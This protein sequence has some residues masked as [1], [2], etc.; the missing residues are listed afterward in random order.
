MET[1][2]KN[3]WNIIKCNKKKIIG[4]ASNATNKFVFMIEY[5]KKLENIGIMNLCYYKICC[6]SKKYPPQKNENKF[7]YGKLVEKSL[8]EAFCK[9][10]FICEDLDKKHKFGSEYKNDIT[11]LGM[12]VSM[13]S[14][15]VFGLFI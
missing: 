5:M 8:M 14:C 1:T 13:S 9:M 12:N 6:I 7:I 4:F 2:Q 15:L 10:G 11:L 3:Y